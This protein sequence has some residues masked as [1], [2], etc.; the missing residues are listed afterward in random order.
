MDFGY[1]YS[2]FQEDI[3]DRFPE[4]LFYEL[5]LNIFVLLDHGH[6][7]FNHRAYLHGGFNTNNLVIKETYISA[8]IYLWSQNYSI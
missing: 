8:V 2:Y 6:G 7:K 4:P 3:D 1:Q 5:Y